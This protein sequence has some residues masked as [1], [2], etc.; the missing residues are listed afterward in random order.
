[1]TKERSYLTKKEQQELYLAL[2]YGG[3]NYGWEPYIEKKHFVLTNPEDLASFDLYT[4]A[5]NFRGSGHFEWELWLAVWLIEAARESLD[6]G[7]ECDI[8]RAF[9]TEQL[10]RPKTKGADYR[11]LKPEQ[12]RS[13]IGR[14]FTVIEET[15]EHCILSLNS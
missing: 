8:S 11:R 2:Y 10:A 15:E 14:F 6:K 9:N 5:C 12:V 4:L 1:M 7:I 13:H 3:N